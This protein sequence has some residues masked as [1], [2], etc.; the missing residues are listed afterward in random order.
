MGQ[1]YGLSDKFFTIMKASDR[2]ALEHSREE[3]TTVADIGRCLREARE[4]RGLTVEKMAEMTG[5]SAA[6]ISNY[7]NGKTSKPALRILQL[8]AAAVG[9]APESL[10]GGGP[11]RLEGDATIQAELL[12]LRLEEQEHHERMQSRFSDL[13]NRIG[14][15]F[16]SLDDEAH[17]PAII[18]NCGQYY[19]CHL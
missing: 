18:T 1:F 14:K 13:L 19:G 11:V 5:I 10:L 3:G 12:A 2:M 8:M 9:I 6:T 4:E 15:R 7:E 17:P 16:A